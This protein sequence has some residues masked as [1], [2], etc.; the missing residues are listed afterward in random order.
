M[1]KIENSIPTDKET[2]TQFQNKVRLKLPNDYI[3][4]LERYNGGYPEPCIIHMKVTSRREVESSCIRSFFGFGLENGD[5]LAENYGFYRKFIPK[6]SIPICCDSDGNVI[7]MSLSIENYC[8]IYLW[9][10]ERAPEHRAELHELQYITDSFTDF[11]NRI[12][13]YDPDTAD[14]NENDLISIW[15]HPDFDKIINGD[16]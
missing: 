1:I 8:E 4:F 5:E 14:M 7:L 10:H 9:N 11:L 3:A 15:I 16:I 2:I 6:E 13:P 12:V